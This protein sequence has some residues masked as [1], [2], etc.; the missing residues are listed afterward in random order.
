[1]IFFVKHSIIEFDFVTYRR[2]TKANSLNHF[3]DNFN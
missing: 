2:S 1:M 3:D